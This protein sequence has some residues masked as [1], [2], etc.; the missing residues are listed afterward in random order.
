M[1]NKL[2][3]LI[4]PKAAQ[5]MEEIFEYISED[6]LSPKAAFDLIEKFNSGF[7]NIR[8]FPKS[9]PLTNN[10][11]VQD[12]LIRKLI[13]ENYIIFYRFNEEKN[14]IEI[15]RVLYG[16]SNWIDVL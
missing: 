7:D 5:D 9:C 6:L 12:K 13:I 16:M 15:V 1:Q 3:L 10:E 4:Y 11:A 2:A 14:S 8:F